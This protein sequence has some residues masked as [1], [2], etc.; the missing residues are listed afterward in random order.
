MRYLD[1]NLSCL[2]YEGEYSSLS[3]ASSVEFGEIATDTSKISDGC[4]FICLRGTKYNTHKIIPYIESKGASAIIV[5][6]G[7]EYCPNC[8][9]DV[10]CIDE[11]E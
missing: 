11:Y 6:E 9:Y 8:G 10:Y 2:L 1:L 4:V 5:E 3:P 7:E